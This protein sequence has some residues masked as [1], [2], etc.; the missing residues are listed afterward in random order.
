MDNFFCPLWVLPVTNVF[1]VQLRI[2]VF[3][4]EWLFKF[5]DNTGFGHLPT[6]SKRGISAQSGANWES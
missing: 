5:F 6:V 4:C 2:L 3:D 1:F